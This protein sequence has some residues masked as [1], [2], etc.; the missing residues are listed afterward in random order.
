MTTRRIPSVFLTQS[1]LNTNTFLTAPRIHFLPVSLPR[2]RNFQTTSIR[3]E[4]RANTSV[5]RDPAPK[6]VRG[7][8]KLFKDADAAVEDLKSGAVILSAGFGICGTAGGAPLI[9]QSCKITSS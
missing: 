3:S 5:K 7:Q 4:Q 2:A 9:L 1:R 8:S 6:V